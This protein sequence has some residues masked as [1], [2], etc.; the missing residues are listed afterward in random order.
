MVNMEPVIAPFVAQI[1]FRLGNFV[2]M[3]RESV[4]NSTG[5]DVQILSQ[6]LHGNAGAFNVPSGIAHA[7]GRIPFQGL[8]L[9]FGFGKPEYKIVLVLLVDVLFHAFPHAHG[10]IF[11]IMVIENI[12]FFQGGSVK[13]HVAPCHIGLSLFQQSLHHMD[14]FLNTVGSRLHHIRTLDVQLVTIRKKGIGV[15]FC[16][17]HH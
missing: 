5:M 2:G 6:V 16:D 14:I 15:K 12:V 3:V 13:I 8:V 11:L 10:K 1:A 4:V 17:L 9:K 7:P